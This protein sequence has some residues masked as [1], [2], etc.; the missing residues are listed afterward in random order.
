MVAAMVALV[1]LIGYLDYITGPDFGFS[2]FYLPPIVA[3]GWLY[4]RRASLV[5]AFTAA[6]AWF[7]ADYLIRVSLPISLWNGLTRLVIYAAQGVIVAMLSEDRQREAALGRTDAVTKLANSRAFVEALKNATRERSDVSVMYVDLDNFKRV[8]DLFGHGAGDAILEQTAAA[9]SASVRSTD[10]PARVGGDEFA[11]LFKDI[12]NDGAEAIAARF[13]EN[14]RLIAREVE[15]TGFNASIG[16][17]IS[18]RHSS[19]DELITVA[20]DAMYAAKRRQK[21]SFEIRSLAATAPAD[22]DDTSRRRRVIDRVTKISFGAR[23]R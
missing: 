2:L 9:L 16:F 12:D 18:R 4:G 14:V 19:P 22:S 1:I 15:G 3:A 17:A 7:L 11:V 21:G 6:G 8:N 10:L 13:L 23:S 20:D 5:V